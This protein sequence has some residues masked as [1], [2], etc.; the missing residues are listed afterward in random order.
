MTPEQLCGEI[1]MLGA[2]KRINPRESFNFCHW[3]HIG[4]SSSYSEHVGAFNL[5]NIKRLKR[6]FRGR[7]A[8]LTEIAP[9]NIFFN[10]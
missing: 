6:D 9:K 10:W 4:L 7:A 8:V 3:T 5:A 1:K 2:I